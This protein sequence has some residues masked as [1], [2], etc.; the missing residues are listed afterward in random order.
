M[1]HD[2]MHLY[3]F[4]EAAGNFQQVNFNKENK[5][6]G[7]DPVNVWVQ[8]D[9]QVNNAWFIP[10][11]DG[12]PP[13]V[14]FALFDWTN[15]RRDTDMD[16]TVVIH[17]LTHGL[18]TRLVGGPSSVSCLSSLES[19]GLAEGWSD[20]VAI[21]FSTQSSHTRL[22]ERFIAAYAS[23]DRLGVR[24]APYTTNM[25]R[26]TFTYQKAGEVILSK[27]PQPPHSIGEAWATML[28]EVYW[29]LVDASGFSSLLMEDARSGTGNVNF[30][31]LLVFSLKIVGCNPTFLTARQSMLAANDHLFA[32]AYR[33]E[34]WRGFAKRGLGVSAN[35]QYQNAFDLPSGC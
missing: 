35:N 7:D 3:G 29:N 14:H 26:N 28:F 2:I 12:N 34:I 24:S 32:G 10:A 22:T 20:I 21:V 9:S 30:L 6:R 13:D 25:N 33:C 17:E 5:G 4:D 15:P 18:T 23:G 16:N 1:Y 27:S 31:W 19:R 8:E 11:T